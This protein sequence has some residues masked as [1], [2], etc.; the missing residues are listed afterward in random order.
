VREN[1]NSFN[2]W[3]NVINENK[4]IRGHMFTQKPPTEKSIYF[5]TLIFGSKNGISNIWGYCPNIRGLIGYLQYSFLQEAFYKWIYGQEKLV[6]KIPHLKVDKIANEGEKLNKISKEVSIN[7]KNDYEFL[8]NLWG[9]PTNKSEMELRKFVADFNRKWIG[10]NKGFLYIK[11][12]RT[13]EELGEFVIS[14]MLITSTETELE[15]KVGMTLDE[16]RNTCKFAIKNSSQG[17]KF[18]RVLLKKLSEVY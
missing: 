18:R 9:M 15:N 1:Y 8:N 2:Y 14:S 7:M 12:F 13:P 4:T 6:T 10:D 17:E 16:W 5:H 3:E 11:V